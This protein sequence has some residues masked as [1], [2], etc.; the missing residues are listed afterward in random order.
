MV[1]MPCDSFRLV[2]VMLLGKMQFLYQ[3]ELFEK[4]EVAVDSGQA[5][6]GLLYPS[7][8]IKLVS[9]EVPPRFEYQVEEESTLTG[10]AFADQC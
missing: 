8:A 9:I 7:Q 3:T 2:M 5:D 1:V 6:S 10:S 4:L